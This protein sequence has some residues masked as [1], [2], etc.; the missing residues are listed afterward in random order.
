MELVNKRDV[1]DFNT[2]LNQTTFTGQVEALNGELK[3]LHGRLGE[4][5]SMITLDIRVEESGNYSVSINATTLAEITVLSNSVGNIL[6]EVENSLKPN[7][8]E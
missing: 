8:N 4:P 5:S 6:Q 3:E 2:V 1:Y 7:I